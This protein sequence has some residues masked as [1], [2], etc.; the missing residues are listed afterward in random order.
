VAGHPA[1]IVVHQ[2]G[3]VDEV[4]VAGIAAGV[5]R[6]AD[7]AEVRV[8]IGAGDT[9]LMFTDGVDEA[10]GADGFYGMDRLLAL[11]PD[12]AGAG[13]VALCEA[14]EQSV[15]EHLDGRAH[16]DIALLAVSCEG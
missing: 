14:V 3:A 4:D 1:P 13:P 6:G 5:V 11:L 2:D 10:R 15:V 16:D 12:Y 9:M 8:H 7:Y